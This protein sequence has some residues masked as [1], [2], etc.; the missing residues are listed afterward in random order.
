LP[1]GCAYNNNNNNNTKNDI[2]HDNVYRYHNL[3]MG[4]TTSSVWRT[5]TYNRHK[6]AIVKQRLEQINTCRG[7]TISHNNNNNNNNIST[8]QGVTTRHQTTPPDNI[9]HQLI[10]SMVSRPKI[11]AMDI[12]EQQMHRKGGPLT[13]ADYIS[14]IIALEPS[15][16]NKIFE[17]NTISIADLILIIRTIIYNPDRYNPNHPATTTDQY[18]P[19]LI[20]DQFDDTTMAENPYQQVK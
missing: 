17:L 3:N 1:F 19:N 20:T 10:H 2:T 12:A 6:D 16:A 4:G 14:I 5:P 15:H 13:K 8:Q 18:Y 9:S 11:S 7:E